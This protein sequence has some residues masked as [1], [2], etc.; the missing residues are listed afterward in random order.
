MLSGVF[1]QE[2]YSVWLLAL[3]AVCGASLAWGIARRQLSFVA[4][5]AVYGYIGVSVILVRDINGGAAIL[6]YFLFT[7]VAMLVM[8]VQIARRFGKEA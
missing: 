3:L 2:G 8:L 7:G 6:S 4:Y 5:A 1:S